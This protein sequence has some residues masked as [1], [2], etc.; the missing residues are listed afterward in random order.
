MPT[1]YERLAN[2]NVKGP[3]KRVLR[4]FVQR[5][6]I[7]V[8]KPWELDPPCFRDILR[9]R[10]MEQLAGAHDVVVA[11]QTPRNNGKV[12]GL[13]GETA[14]PRRGSEKPRGKS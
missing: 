9:R 8:Q 6:R 11:G 7:D 12:T 10:V 2:K 4:D 5:R 14:S 3:R 13:G 1:E